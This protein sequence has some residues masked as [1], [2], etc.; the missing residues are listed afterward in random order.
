MGAN[1]IA[2]MWID[3]TCGSMRAAAATRTQ[4][5]AAVHYSTVQYIQYRTVQVPSTAFLV[6]RVRVS[7]W[8]LG[9]VAESYASIL[10]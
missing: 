8:H 5:I 3:P 7:W 6:H 4:N 9:Q 2:W 1:W 10:A